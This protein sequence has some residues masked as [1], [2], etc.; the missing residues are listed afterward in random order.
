[1]LLYALFTCQ[2]TIFR[3]AEAVLAKV[4]RR[5]VP[6]VMHDARGQDRRRH[7]ETR[8]A[9]F[10]SGMAKLVQ[11]LRQ[12]AKPS[13]TFSLDA[14]R[15]GGMTEPRNAFQIERGEQNGTDNSLYRSIA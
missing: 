2:A 12:V 9:L 11:R 13:Q 5:G 6:L 7:S 10:G 4:P 14:C 1:M 3:D 8:R 15:H